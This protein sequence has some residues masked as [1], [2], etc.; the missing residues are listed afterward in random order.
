[1][2]IT[3]LF[4]IFESV[5]D[6]KRC[7]DYLNK[8][9]GNDK[10]F[11]FSKFEKT[12][13]NCADF[14]KKAGLSDIE[15]LPVKA[16]GKTKYG[17]WVIPQ[18]WDA[19]H[20]VLKSA[21]GNFIFANYKETPC[22]LVMYSA[23]TPKGGLT[24]EAIIIEEGEYEESNLQ[25]KIFVTSCP[26]RDIVPLAK[27]HGAVGIVSDY[28]PLYEGVRDNLDEIQN[29]SK[30]ENDF[31]IPINDTDM[32]AFSISPKNGKLLR[33]CILK[34]KKFLLHAEVE[35]KLYDGECY[36][37]SGKIKGEIDDSVCIYGHLY[38]P[39]AHDNASGCAVI[40]EL[41]A[42]INDAI[43]K[44]ILPKP[45]QTLNFIVGY[46]CV[47][48]MAWILAKERNAVCGFVADMVGTDKIDNTHMCI[49]HAP[50]SN[51]SF[52]DAYIDNIIEEYKKYSKDNFIWES[53][54]FSIGTDNI[55]AD[56]YF[57]APTPAMIA[58][59]AL[60]YHSSFDTPDRIESDVIFRNGVII[61]TYLFGLATAEI[62]DVE[63]L[64]KM[65]VEYINKIENIYFR[66]EILKKAKQSM[67]DF[68]PDFTPVRDG[69][70]DVPYE[71][72]N[73]TRN[74]DVVGAVPY[75]PPDYTG[76]KA[77]LIPKRK[78]AGCLTFRGNPEL[79]DA[80]WQP[81]WN[82]RLNL[83]LFWADGKRNL[84]EITILSAME[85]GEYSENEIK[86]RWEWMT[87]YFEFLADKGYI[88]LN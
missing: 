39:G 70:H 58:E 49:W 44:G 75:N 80:P 86:S 20:A 18:A 51:L 78:V 83:P 1:M 24:A 37:V 79:A 21:G 8:I 72:F 62:N 33:E 34:N 42:C 36:T 25:G 38:E 54:G 56:P 50:M 46:E 76:Q 40:L 3:E 35:T 12:A 5:F 48:S 63:Q 32:F 13:Y 14:M 28:I 71:K 88:T 65:T 81:A 85:T 53:K 26:V 30:W 57:K 23:S 84:W 64:W 87:E 27:E 9:Y 41:A 11:S 69:A 45:K 60:S 67:I 59:P 74:R 29:V 10:Y 16:D 31:F 22:S 19:E 77:Y 15:M 6:T 68:C 52:A 66:Q 73:N 17:D 43:N 2:N 82:N 55:L 4:K 61:G 7:L 47:G